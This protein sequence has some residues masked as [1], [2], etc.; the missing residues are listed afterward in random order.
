MEMDR[1]KGPRRE[2]QGNTHVHMYTHAHMY[3][4]MHVYSRT[5]MHTHSRTGLGSWQERRE[6]AARNS[7]RRQEHIWRCCL[8]FLGAAE[9]PAG[10]GSSAPRPR[11][12][13]QASAPGEGRGGGQGRPSQSLSSTPCWWPWDGLVLGPSAHHSSRSLLPTVPSLLLTIT[14]YVH[15]V[16]QLG[17]CLSPLD[18]RVEPPAPLPCLLSPHPASN[19]GQFWKR[20]GGLNPWSPASLPLC[21]P[22]LSHAAPWL[23]PHLLGG[24]EKHRGRETCPRTQL[25]GDTR[26]SVSTEVMP[27]LGV[28]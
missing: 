7:R 19:Q 16:S 22:A 13:S 12:G 5:H 15:A 1:D 23:G 11:A 8:L 10:G 18:T 25:G 9:A 24:P 14:T 17:P 3:T 28:Q 4:R 21:L 2:Q 26:V 27:P 20:G 6:R